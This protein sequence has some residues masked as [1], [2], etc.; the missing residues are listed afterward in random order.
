MIY[1]TLTKKA[2][3]I[4][5][6]AHKDQIDKSGLPYVFHPFHL[7]EQ[8]DDESSTCVALLHDVVED[9]NYTIEDLERHGFPSDVIEAIKLL[10]HSKDLPYFDYINKVKSNSLATKVKIA[11]L[12]HNSDISRL[13]KINED[14]LKRIEK[15]N[16]AVKLLEY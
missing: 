9:S 7:A 3:K 16:K 1:T 5:Y 12:K 15:Y 6:E 11:D 2:L 8:M 13:N 10:T 4:A 14:D